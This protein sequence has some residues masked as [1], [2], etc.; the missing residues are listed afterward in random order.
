M[1]ETR[2][3]VKETRASHTPVP[4]ENDSPSPKKTIK[5]QRVEKGESTEKRVSVKKTQPKK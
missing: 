4:T 5:E 1:C 2:Q 3:S